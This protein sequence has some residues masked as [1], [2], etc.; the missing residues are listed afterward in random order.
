MHLRPG[1]EP[2]IDSPR[3]SLLSPRVS[4]RVSP[5]VSRVL[6]R[7][8]EERF[9][10]GSAASGGPLNC[11]MLRPALPDSATFRVT[12]ARRSQLLLAGSALLLAYA[13]LR[14]AWLSDDGLITFRTIDHFVNGDGLRFNLAERVQSY[15]HPLW[16]FVL[17]PFYA[18]TREAFYTP[19]L[20]SLV[21][22]TA[23]VAALVLAALRE[24]RFGAATAAVV[25]LVSSKAF[26]D[27]T[28]SGLETPLSY[29]LLALFVNVYFRP[30]ERA[31]SETRRLGWLGLL[32][33][34]AF[35]NRMDS[36]LLL[37][38]AGG[39]RLVQALRGGAPARRVLGAVAAGAA[40]AVAWL[41][42]ALVYYGAPFPNTFQAKLATG[43]DPALLLEQGVFYLVH[44]ARTDPATLLV[45]TFAVG[46]AVRDAIRH[47]RPDAACL[48][49]GIGLQLLYVVRVGGDFMA[50]RFLAL[51]F[52]AGVAALVHLRWPASRFGALAAVCLALSLVHASAPLRAGPD[53]SVRDE[54]QIVADRGIS[55]E[56]GFY[57]P[58]RGLLAPE[59]ERDLH[60]GSKCT[61]NGAAVV[62]RNVCGELGYE[63]FTACRGDFLADRCALADPLL[64][65]MPM[66]DPVHWRVG[67]Y[68]RR[69]PRGY[70]ESL[71]RDA[72]LLV[73]PA[74]HAL[75]DDIRSATRAPLFAAG[76][77][78]AIL[79]LNLR[80]LSPKPPAGAQPRR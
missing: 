61:G 77:W 26:V 80:P 12:L 72:N 67:H 55:D 11:S 23:G 43:I 70:R 7:S 2:V 75:Y 74:H 62:V 68:F 4:P 66:I 17:A 21:A 24:R 45:P 63:G 59:A 42:F 14:S 58:R 3:V 40:P 5:V 76:R 1:P 29:L 46:L 54:E 38:P 27:Y 69:V 10:K 13:M 50:G 8:P 44:A 16:L 53:Y 64:A 28:S 78:E 60:A 32:A 31:G 79:R 9:R 33:S 49:A 65:R 47:R 41:A 52:L 36:A 15:T 71:E 20:V 30:V 37:A 34:L 25:C 39:L 57:Y 6:A 19:I 51:P 73:D 35:L 56:R 18:A 48:A 22:S